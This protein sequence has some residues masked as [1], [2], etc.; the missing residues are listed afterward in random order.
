MLV[1][2][3]ELTKLVGESQNQLVSMLGCHSFY[4]YHRPLKDYNY[5]KSFKFSRNE[6]YFGIVGGV[7]W[8][9]Y[10]AIFAFGSNSSRGEG[11][12]N[13]SVC[14]SVCLLLNCVHSLMIKTI[15]AIITHET[16]QSHW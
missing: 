4:A 9:K 3:K 16:N 10:N 1:K 15:V 13:W 5:W 7:V 12:L 14:V 2:R 8:F 6:L 11:Y